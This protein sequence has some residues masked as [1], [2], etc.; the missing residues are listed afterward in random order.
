MWFDSSN[1]KIHPPIDVYDLNGYVLP[2]AGTLYTGNIISHTLRFRP[3]KHIKYIYILYYPSSEEPNIDNMYYHEYYVPWKC[4]EYILGNN[5]HYQGFNLRNN[6][7]H[8]IPRIASNTLIVVSADFSHHYPIQKA[9]ELEN[10]A[11][12]SLMFRE[13]KQTEYTN[14][15]YDMISFHKL[16]SIFLYFT[17]LHDRHIKITC[18]I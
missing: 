5:Y 6:I 4:M 2:H 7:D 9:I 18:F 10:K 3:M 12:H 11:A 1:L 15:V 17:I 14:I 13:L 8:H 16:Y